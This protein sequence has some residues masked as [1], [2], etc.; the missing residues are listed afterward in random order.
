MN[1]YHNIILIIETQI[2]IKSIRR[3]KNTMMN[4]VVSNF[5]IKKIISGGQ[6]GVDRAALDVAILLNIPHGGWCPKSRKA[7]DGV[8]SPYYNLKETASE[9]YNERTAWNVS[10]S[11]GTLIIV[12]GKP[13]GGTLLT[14]NVAEQLKKPFFIFNL[15]KDNNI[16]SVINWINENKIKILNIAGPRASQVSDIY[17]SSYQLLKQLFCHPSFLLCATTEEKIVKSKD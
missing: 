2:S 17:Q 3:I 7:E 15:D 11:D 8:I 1:L 12:K 13:I 14:K 6:T 5:I 16:D 4:K 10:D 9:E